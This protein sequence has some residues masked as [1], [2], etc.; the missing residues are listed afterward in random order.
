MP[1]PRWMI[2][3]LRMALVRAMPSLPVSSQG[4]PQPVLT[5]LS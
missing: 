3:G 5:D 1:F 2:Q 4:E